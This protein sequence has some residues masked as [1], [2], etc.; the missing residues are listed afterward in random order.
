MQYLTVFF[1]L[2]FMPLS[3][4]FAIVECP[5][6]KLYAIQSIKISGNLKTKTKVIAR[7]LKVVPDKPICQI[8]IDDG[9]NR[10][11]RTGLFSSVDFELS[12]ADNPGFKTLEIKVV[13]RW[14]TIP[15]FKVNSG[16]GVSQYTLGVYDPNVFGEYWEA[17]TQYE[18]L[19]GAS[20]G[21]L[22]F[23]NPRFLDRDQ[24]IDLQYWNT[25]RIR[26]KYDQNR[27]QPKIKNGFLHEREKI[28]AD[29]FREI[30]TDKVVRISFDYNDDH[31]STKLLP[32]EVLTQ[33]GS[34]PTLPPATEILI[35]KVGFEWGRINGNPQ[36]LDGSLLGVY[37][38]YAQPIKSN[39]DSFVQGDM[40]YTLFKPFLPGWQFAQRF[41]VG[42]TTT[43][44][45]QY[46]HYL[47]G[48]DRI[49]GFADNRFSARHYGL[50]NSELR[51]LVLERPSA[52]LQGVGFIDF[53]SVGDKFSDLNQIHAASIGAG[54]RVILPK[55]YR[56]V[57]RL[58]YAKPIIKN[59]TMNI[60]LGVQQF[61]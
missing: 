49:R 8:N 2:L 57:V 59:D 1:L 43:E 61:F 16:G 55:F 41:L 29:Y 60:S 15:I 23:K 35:T 13:E 58:D 34:D 19:S 39:V 5:A 54:V 42:S 6:D 3:P 48:L 36:S 10:I 4:S 51:Y 24:G 45:L 28:Y 25:K 14:T 52:L 21:V 18:N 32:D 11:K 27:N 31:F 12:S 40:S 46:W 50:S 9:I 47:G 38:G 37:F 33:I 44:I 17:G 22:W 26:I 20:S 56:F 30:S 53:A 7:E